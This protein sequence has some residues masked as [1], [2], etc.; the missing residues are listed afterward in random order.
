MEVTNK[1]ARK[2]FI[3]WYFDKFKDTIPT[4]KEELIAEGVSVWKFEDLLDI[5]GDIPKDIQ[6]A[7]KYS[8]YIDDEMKNYQADMEVQDFEQFGENKI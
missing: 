5:C 1:Q 2:L 7:L 6:Q 3:D 8:D 4:M